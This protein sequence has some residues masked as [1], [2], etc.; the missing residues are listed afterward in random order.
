MP[1]DTH[2]T[3][4]CLLWSLFLC[5]LTL[6][7]DRP[8]CWW[9]TRLG[10]VCNMASPYS[11][12][13]CTHTHTHTSLGSGNGAGWLLPLFC[14]VQVSC[15]FGFTSHALSMKVVAYAGILNTHEVPP[16][17]HGDDACRLLGYLLSL[18]KFGV[19]FSAYGFFFC[20]GICL[21]RCLLGLNHVVTFSQAVQSLRSL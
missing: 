15:F 17:T 19:L 13:M 6:I 4:H 2:K 7:R 3:W 21:D 5:C 8:V 10:D 12:R 14:L 20:N 18:C 11:F 16:L 9:R 1:V